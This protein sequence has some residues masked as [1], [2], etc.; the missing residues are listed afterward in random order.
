MAY[1]AFA[2]LAMPMT[3]SD[4]VGLV[5]VSVCVSVSAAADPVSV[6][7]TASVAVSVPVAEPAVSDEVPVF[8]SVG[9]VQAHRIAMRQHQTCC[10]QKQFSPMFHV[11]DRSFL[12]NAV[13]FGGSG[14]PEWRSLRLPGHKTPVRKSIF[15]LLSSAHPRNCRSVPRA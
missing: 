8:V 1:P 15:R 13:V 9:P 7:V 4:T 3:S 14:L 11:Y 5:S 2:T 10:H 6:P 12:T